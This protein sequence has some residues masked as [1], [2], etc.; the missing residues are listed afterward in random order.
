MDE[1]LWQLADYPD[2]PHERGLDGC[3]RKLLEGQGPH[4]APLAMPGDIVGLV[5]LEGGQCVIRKAQ[6]NIYADGIPRLTLLPQGADVLITAP[7]S[8]AHSSCGDIHKSPHDLARERGK[9]TG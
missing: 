5:R 8:R 6:Y 1:G 3:A 2:I 4:P 9:S 7:K